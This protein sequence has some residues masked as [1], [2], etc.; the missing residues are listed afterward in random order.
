MAVVNGQPAPHV[1]TAAGH[2]LAK[3]AGQIPANQKFEDLPNLRE[4]RTVG[5]EDMPHVWMPFGGQPLNKQYT[6]PAP[7]LLSTNTVV[8][9]FTT[10]PNWYAVFR[11]VALC[12]S[13]ANF[14][15]GTGA[16]TWR[17]L[18]AGNPVSDFGNVT[19]QIGQIQGAIVPQEV[20]PIIIRPNSTVQ[21]Q[22]DNASWNP[23][24]VY[25]YAI[26][27]GWEWPH[28]KMHF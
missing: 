28:H 20:A 10:R 17:I 19:I 21:I 23:A 22:V 5:I 8:G 12:Q 15:E 11:R 25:V 27:R 24:S 7:A 18:S 3:V 2:F 14:P 13:N 1:R 6:I 9:S 4:L 16:M 26:L